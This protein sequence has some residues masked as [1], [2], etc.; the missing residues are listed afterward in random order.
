MGLLYTDI[1]V[2]RLLR[3]RPAL[4]VVLVYLAKGNTN[5]FKFTFTHAQAH[6]HTTTFSVERHISR[7]STHFRDQPLA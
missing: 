1:L 4:S 2:S 7:V 3:P 5:S 6:T